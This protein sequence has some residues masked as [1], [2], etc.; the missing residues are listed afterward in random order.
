M[1]VR[2]TGLLQCAPSS[3]EDVQLLLHECVCDYP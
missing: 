3:S 1:S 2:A